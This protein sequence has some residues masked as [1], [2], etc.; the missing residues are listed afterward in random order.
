MHYAINLGVP[1]RLCPHISPHALRDGR[2]EEDICVA[3]VKVRVDSNEAHCGFAADETSIRN[4]I[5][6]SANG[7]GL[8]DAS[9]E[10]IRLSYLATYPTDSIKWFR[11]KGCDKIR[12]AIDILIPHVNLNNLKSYDQFLQDKLEEY[13]G[14]SIR[15]TH[16]GNV[17]SSENEEHDLY[18][19]KKGETPIDVL[20]EWQAHIQDV[21]VTK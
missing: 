14:W 8:V 11:W 2:V 17:G 7:F 18:I 6:S 1:V 4:D 15:I 12:E 19:E 9:V 5:T 10:R 13:P 21:M 16:K 20:K 3:Q